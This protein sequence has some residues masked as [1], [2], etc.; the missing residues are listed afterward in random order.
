MSWPIEA[1]LSSEQ[2]FLSLLG[3][4]ACADFPARQ[5]A[6]GNCMRCVCSYFSACS[7]E[8]LADDM[9]S[10]GDGECGISES[11][12]ETICFDKNNVGCNKQIAD[13][14]INLILFPWRVYIV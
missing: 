1:P 13:F 5:F 11:L 12:Q 4:G 8:D 7:S 14:L 10:L 2:I 9:T 3:Y 6:S